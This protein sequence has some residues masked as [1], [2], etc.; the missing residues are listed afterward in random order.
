[1]LNGI[2]RFESGFRNFPSSFKNLSARKVSASS[3][4]VLSWHAPHMLPKTVVSTML[5]QKWTPQSPTEMID[6]MPNNTRN[7]SRDCLPSDCHISGGVVRQRHERCCQTEYLC[8]EGHCVVHN[9]PIGVL[10]GPR[11]WNKKKI[12]HTKNRIML[13]SMP[14][15]TYQH[16]PRSLRR[17]S[18]VFQDTWLRRGRPSRG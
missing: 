9:I 17:S 6:K 3:N 10:G 16:V 8:D 7:T 1:M 18:A 4:T 2:K 5:R 14:F 12:S 11:T 15:W 13:R